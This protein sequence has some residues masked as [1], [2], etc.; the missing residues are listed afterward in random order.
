MSNATVE[1]PAEGDAQADVLAHQ[2]DNAGGVHQE[3]PAGD[4]QREEHAGGDHQEGPASDQEEDHG[5][6]GEEEFHHRF[7]MDE[8]ETNYRPQ[9]L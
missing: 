7:T 2:E 4:A 5:R 8:S 6:G 1:Q 9:R 3:D